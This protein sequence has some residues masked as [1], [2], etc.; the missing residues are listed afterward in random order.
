MCSSKRWKHA[1]EPERHKSRT[2]VK[3]GE[4]NKKDMQE[5]KSEVK[6]ARS[7]K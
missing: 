6:I 1:K 4:V 7:R 2:E 5:M 3:Y